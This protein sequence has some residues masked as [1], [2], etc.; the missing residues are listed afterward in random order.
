MSDTNDISI[1]DKK[2]TST[3][4]SSA[5]AWLRNN[6]RKPVSGPA[7]R[8][9]V[10]ENVDPLEYGRVKVLI[11][12]LTPEKTSSQAAKW[13]WTTNVFGGGQVEYG[14]KR[15]GAIFPHQI[16]S[17]IYVVFMNSDTN[18]ANPIVLGG[19]FQKSKIPKQV[20]DRKK[21]GQHIPRAW[22]Y[23]SPKGHSI[24]CREEDDEESI[25]LISFKGRKIII[26]DKLNQEMISLIGVKGGE[27]QLFEGTEGTIITLI[28]PSGDVITIDEQKQSITAQSRKLVNIVGG[29][30]VTITAGQN[31]TLS[32]PQI[33][34]SGQVTPC[35]SP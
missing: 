14:H 2:E 7:F 29:Q 34:L 15:Y 12:G 16:G 26:S 23:V 13:A 32:A 5:L 6:Q 11:D 30:Q 25:E 33:Y 18:Y 20:F 22:G 4:L 19:F 1:N 17:V 3:G 8:G 27:I 10:V 9:V 35:C 21:P 28:D 24:L 31:I